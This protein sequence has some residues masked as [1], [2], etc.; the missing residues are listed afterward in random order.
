MMFG[1]E[2]K[3]MHI[4]ND[5]KRNNYGFYCNQKYCHYC[6]MLYVSFG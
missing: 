1:K 5:I 4:D 6:C 2:K 3:L